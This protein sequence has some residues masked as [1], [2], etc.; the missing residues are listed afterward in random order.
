MKGFRMSEDVG[1]KY[2]GLHVAAWDLFRHGHE[3]WDDR[4]LYEKVIRQYGE[5]ALDVGCAT[6][7]LILTYIGEGIDVDG[8]DASADMLAICRSKA[9]VAGLQPTLYEQRM[10]RLDLPRTYKTIIVSSSSFTL[11][12][13]LDASRAAMDGFCRHLDQGGALV[14]PFGTPW[15]EGEPT[16]TGWELEKEATREEDGA[17]VRR[18]SRGQYDPETQLQS[19]ECR[20]EVIIDG[21]T[22]MQEHFRS[23]PATRSYTQQQAIA[24]YAGAGFANIRVWKGFTTDAAAEDDKLFTVIGERV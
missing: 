11:L 16:V 19:D 23:Y 17:V 2:C 1:R 22:I 7:R 5:P 4:H 21:K 14:M 15:S 24:V 6:G 12:T 8:V 3:D 13:D 10:E 20:Y 18:W 9:E